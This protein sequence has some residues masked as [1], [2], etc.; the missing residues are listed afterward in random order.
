MIKWLEKLATSACRNLIY[1]RRD[2]AADRYLKR[3]KFASNSWRLSAGRFPRY[4]FLFSVY[5]TDSNSIDARL[6]IKT[7]QIVS[8]ENNV[9]F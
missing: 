2:D 3:L 9:D 1:F 5:K 7:T 4:A 6:F 8:L